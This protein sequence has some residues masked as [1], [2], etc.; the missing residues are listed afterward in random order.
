MV[1]YLDSGYMEIIASFISRVG[2]VTT[3]PSLF[4]AAVIKNYRELAESI[5]E[6][7]N[8]KPVSF[9]VFA[10]DPREFHERGIRLWQ[11]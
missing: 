2:G 7:V 5:L 11:K 6:R 3:N 10:D 9:E 4:K 8:G 1:V